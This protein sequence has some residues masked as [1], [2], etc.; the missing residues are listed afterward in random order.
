MTKERELNRHNRDPFVLHQSIIFGPLL[1]P[2]RS[3]KCP[4][5]S[6]SFAVESW[7]PGVSLMTPRCHSVN[8]PLA[9]LSSFEGV[10]GDKQS[11][12]KS[13]AGS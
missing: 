4:A 3:P 2:G 1:L 8:T 6:E 9:T 11:R 10:S 13:K 12:C 7:V 5:G